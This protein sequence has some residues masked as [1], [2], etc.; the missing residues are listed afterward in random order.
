MINRSYY[1]KNSR[2]L[3]APQLISSDLISNNGYY[4]ILV[5]IPANSNGYKIEVYEGDRK[6]KTERVTHAAKT[7]SYNFVKLQNGSY[8]YKVLLKRGSRYVESNKIEINVELNSEYEEYSITST[9]TMG[10]IVR[11]NDKIYQSKEWWVKGVQP[12][13][14][15][16]IWEELT[17]NVDHNN[18]QLKASLEKI[19]EKYNAK[20]DEEI[21][22]SKYDLNHDGIIDIFD[23][24]MVAK[25]IQ[26]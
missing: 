17:F 13:K 19:S 23:I 25:K 16:K 4:S 20:K 22:D 6:I 2:K 26:E 14:D 1:K 5:D 24:V 21:Y 11:Y 9:Y 3:I 7:F 18:S 8:F 12:D 10:D 15:N